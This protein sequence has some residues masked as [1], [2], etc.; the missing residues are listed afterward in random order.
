MSTTTQT[1]VHAALATQLSNH[2]VLTEEEKLFREALKAV[3]D[4]KR[5]HGMLPEI[6]DNI[7]YARTIEDIEYLFQSERKA[8]SFW[9]ADIG[10]PWLQNLA[11]FAECLWQY[12]PVVD[13]IVTRSDPRVLYAAQHKT[14]YCTQA[15]LWQHQFGAA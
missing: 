15:R 10:K 11:K 14:D 5:K 9:T 12:K 6:F 8:N 1:N 2:R 7:N 13:A 4:G 3:Q